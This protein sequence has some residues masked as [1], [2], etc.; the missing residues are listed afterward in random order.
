MFPLAVE[1]NSDSSFHI[2]VKLREVRISAVNPV[3]PREDR[4]EI[5][6]EVLRRGELA[7]LPTET[8][9]GLCGDALN[10]R[11]MGRI[12]L[13]KGKPADTPILLLLSGPEQA[14][15]LCDRIPERYTELAGMFW[16][17]PLSL[18]I[19]ATDR[20][21]R[22]VTAGT[23]TV[24]VRVPGLALPR[25]LASGL[26][27]PISGVSAN[28]HGQPASRTSAE[29]HRA[30]PEGL[31]LILEGGPAPGGAPSTILDLTGSQPRVLREG[32][33]PVASLRA[34]IG[35]DDRG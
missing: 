4:L 2:M 23:G 14:E 22:E 5:A 17:G 20:V 27:R 24:A 26:G 9:Y 25:R 33:I 11:A 34:V 10:A 12:N 21:P 1:D 29:V 13:L 28:R 8:F 18:V 30:F 32:V 16:P 6:L 7:A 19:P 15:Q 31:A 35:V 3:D